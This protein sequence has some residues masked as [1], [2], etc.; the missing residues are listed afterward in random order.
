MVARPEGAPHDGIRHHSMAWILDRLD[1]GLDG[2]RACG[3]RL[4]VVIPRPTAA[5]YGRPSQLAPV[6]TREI[7]QTSAAGTPL[8]DILTAHDLT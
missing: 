4:G 3:R 6:L 5:P 7:Q 2:C 8:A 1:A